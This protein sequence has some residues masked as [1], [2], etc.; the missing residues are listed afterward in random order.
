MTLDHLGIAADD[1]SADLF[2][3]LLGAAPYKTEVVES[4]GVRTVFF[5]DGGA[6][7]AAPK[8][9]LLESV[10]SGSP[11]A[12]YLESRG[13]GLHHVAFEVEDLEGEMERVRAL[14]IRLLSE[15]PQPGAD[16]KQI[17][18]LHPKDTAG[19][20]VELC[21]SGPLPKAPLAVAYAEGEVHG[22]S[23]GHVD[24]PILVAL[25]GALG[26][27]EQLERFVPIWAERFRV[28]ALDLPAHGRSVVEG[29]MTWERFAR[30]VI[31]VLDTLA[32]SDVR[33]FGYSLG[34][35]VAMEV[36]RQRP[37]AVARLA[38]H[39]TNTQWTQREVEQMTEGLR[40][41]PPA[42]A[43]RMEALHGS[44]WRENVDRMIAFSEGLPSAWIEDAALAEVRQPALVSI[45]DSDGLFDVEA[46]LHLARTLP[47]ARLWVIPGARHALGSLDAP[48]FARTIADHLQ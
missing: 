30:G 12:R 27:T 24:A 18:F 41:V 37:D 1:A 7:G 34:A 14:G 43:E 26:T 32:L 13:P 11:I 42:V 44:L 45:G 15:T 6:S 36:A 23:V 4:Q 9:E 21:A 33:M 5:G 48:A 2:R 28:I 8:L 16:G 19:V 39:A 29:E 31:A 40:E 47:D 35:A 17:V 22:W 25:H 10:A 20:L 38:L 46:A 3:R